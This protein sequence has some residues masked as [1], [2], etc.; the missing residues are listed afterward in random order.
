MLAVL[1][2]SLLPAVERGEVDAT[3]PAIGRITSGNLLVSRTCTGTLI[4]PDLVLTA[5]HCVYPAG[6]LTFDVTG[7]DGTS[8][9]QG[10]GVAT[11][12]AHPEFAPQG[13]DAPNDGTHALNDVGILKLREAVP[14][15][16]A[17]PLRI[18]RGALDEDIGGENVRAVGYGATR[19]GP[20]VASSAR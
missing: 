8:T 13:D 17:A 6:E 5:A 15:D 16:V 2:L 19:S 18:R 20:P 9:V 7:E 4:G 3:M 10:F 12:L 14:D 11:A 1:L